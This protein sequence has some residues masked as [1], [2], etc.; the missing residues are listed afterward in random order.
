MKKI[1]ILG[2]TSAIAIACARHW[3]Q[4]GNEFVLAARDEEKLEQI[5]DDLSARGVV[6]H[7]RK[8]DFSDYQQHQHLCDECLNILGRVD[9]LLLAF[10]TLP[11]QEEC[12]KS[13]YTAINEFHNN[14]L[15]AISLLTYFAKKMEAQKTG[16]IA[17][18]SSVAGDRG[19]PTNYLYGA[20]KSALSTF[21]SGLRARLFSSGVHLATIKP[22]FV[23]TPM[24][25][26][27]SLP[28]LLTAS[29]EQVA[30]DIDKAIVNK[31]SVVYSR[32]YWRYIMGVIILIPNVIFNR[33]NL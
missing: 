21:C 16:A 11:N 10:G 7:T 8:I 14:G 25:E 32:W 30:I 27:L 31:K 19:R 2:A 23:D 9:I 15:S 33:L 12:E 3:S 28:S 24:T 6:T 26:H 20:A 29:P 17:V 5:S 1:V 4:K 13:A 22:G 18:I